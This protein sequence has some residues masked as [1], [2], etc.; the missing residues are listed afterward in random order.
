MSEELARIEVIG[1]R[2]VVAQLKDLDPTL[3]KESIKAMK[4][5]AKPMQD[6]ARALVPASAPLS[7]MA[8]AWKNKLPW[9]RKAVTGITVRYGGKYSKSTTSWPLISLQQKDPAGSIFDMAGRAT[10]NPLGNA[11]TSR[12]GAPSRA[13]WR[14]AEANITSVQEGVKQAADDAAAQVNRKVSER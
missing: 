4:T 10:S 6:A 13:M 5:A 9:T 1:V 3:R 12:Y 8:R 11:L 2:E 7:G 14:A